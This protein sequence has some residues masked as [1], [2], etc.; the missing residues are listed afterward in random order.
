MSARACDG[1]RK[2][3]DFAHRVRTCLLSV[4][5]GC[6]RSRKDVFAV[7]RCGRTCVCRARKVTSQRNSGIAHTR[8]QPSDRV[9]GFCRYYV[10]LRLFWHFSFRPLFPLVR[11]RSR[12]RLR[13]CASHGSFSKNR[14]ASPDTHTLRQVL[15]QHTARALSKG[16]ARARFAA[17][18][19]RELLLVVSFC[20]AKKMAV[21]C[22]SLL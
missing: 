15:V 4:T 3:A 21:C 13:R 10:C 7:C 22:S 2:R 11:M 8:F 12:V 6:A 18:F 14:G 19:G 20:S 9:L 17:A 16:P 5:A 1:G